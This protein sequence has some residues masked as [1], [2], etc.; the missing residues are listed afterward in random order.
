MKRCKVIRLKVQR[1]EGLKVVKL[2]VGI[3]PWNLR[4]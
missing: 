4:L 2:K 3:R 1:F